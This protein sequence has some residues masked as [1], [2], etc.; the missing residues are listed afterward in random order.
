[1]II[2]TPIISLVVSGGNISADA[3]PQESLAVTWP[4]LTEQILL[5]ENLRAVPVIIN[6][7]S[8]C[9]KVM[10]VERRTAERDVSEIMSLEAIGH[11]GRNHLCEPNHDH[12]PA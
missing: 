9:H 4:H 1:M 8:V 6:E 2:M 5:L 11:S 3:K 12:M 7:A 10:Y